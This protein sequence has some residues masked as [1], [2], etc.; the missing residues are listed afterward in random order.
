MYL[1]L[2]LRVI[3]Y[4]DVDSR[5]LVRNM[6]SIAHLPV[7]FLSDIFHWR[8]SNRLFGK[9]AAR[10]CFLFVFLNNFQTRHM[11]RTLTNALEQMF[12]VVAFNY[13]IDQ[14]NKFNFNTVVLTALITVSFMIRNTS[15]VGWL[16]LL[17][18]KVLFEGS[19]V[20]FIKSG[21]FVALPILFFLV[22]V[23]TEFYQSDK[24]VFTGYNF[25]EMNVLLGLSKYFGEE[26]WYNYLFIEIPKYTTLMYFFLP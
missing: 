4:L 2:P 25:L 9:D 22:W 11:V 26:P 13:F 18:Y 16:P 7:V 5:W 15:P 14:K 17:G 19:L 1:T 6:P 12:T 10:M 24:W 23:D 3:K 20:P 8:V 21:I